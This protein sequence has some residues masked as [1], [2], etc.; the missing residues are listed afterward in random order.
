MS[1][2]SACRLGVPIVAATLLIASAP[3]AAEASPLVAR[4][5]AHVGPVPAVADPV[6]VSA[7]STDGQIR[8]RV[9]FPSSTLEPAVAT[10]ATMTVKNITDHRVTVD[11]GFLSASLRLYSGGSM[12]LDTGY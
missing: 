2:S 10:G 5:S 8:C 3:L 6:V 11:I 4:P 7:R 9:R 1:R 12:V